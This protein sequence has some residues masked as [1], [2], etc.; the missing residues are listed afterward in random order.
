MVVPISI[1]MTVYNRERYLKEAIESLLAQTRQDFE[2]IVWDDGSTDS[3]IEI[4]H[5]YAQQ[6]RRVR[7]IASAHQGRCPA[8]NQAI[9][10]SQGEYIGFVDSDDLL[11]PTALEETARVLKLCSP[12]AGVVY[13]DFMVID[14]NSKVAGYG[15][16]CRIP[17]S[18]AR[19]LAVFMT[20]HF[21]LL[22]RECL[23]QVGGINESLKHLEDWDLC[24]RL[25]EVTEFRHIKKP[26]YYWRRHLANSMGDAMNLS[27][28]DIILDAR[29][30]IAAT[31]ERR[32]LADRFEMVDEVKTVIEEDSAKLAYQHK[33]YFQERHGE[34]KRLSIEDMVRIQLD[35][36]CR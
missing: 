24:A 25:S 3:S 8:L 1:I 21:R 6:D 30:I 22:R 15:T 27:S 13:T 11:A 32:G 4:A 36:D 19:L 29:K 23:K 20:F 14:E 28:M 12:E 16:R 2:L 9:A 26:L 18:K 10:Q 34:K 5:H 33:F 35:D 17:Y 7:A 31:L